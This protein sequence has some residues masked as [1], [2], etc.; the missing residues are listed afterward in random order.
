[1][2]TMLVLSQVWL[3]ISFLTKEK[4]LQATAMGIAVFWLVGYAYKVY[5]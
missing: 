5:M 1:M 3:M 4:V 2:D